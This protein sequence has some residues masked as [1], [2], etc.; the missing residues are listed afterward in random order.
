MKMYVN[1]DKGNSKKIKNI[2]KYFTPEVIKMVIS[3][4]DYIK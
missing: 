2:I 4:E 3:Q 1:L